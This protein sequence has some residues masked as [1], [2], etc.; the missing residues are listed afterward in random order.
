M[1]VVVITW[2]ERLKNRLLPR[3]IFR[4]QRFRFYAKPA[5]GKY[6]EGGYREW[7]PL[8]GTTSEIVRF[9]QRSLTIKAITQIALATRICADNDRQ[10]ADF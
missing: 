10:A 9:G 8:R 7:A 6:G 2:T 3:T 4:L 1:I 5:G